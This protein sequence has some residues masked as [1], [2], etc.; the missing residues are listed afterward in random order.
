MTS[1]WFGTALPRA[2]GQRPLEERTAMIHPPRRSRTV[3][4]LSPV[5]MTLLTAFA[6]THT[7]VTAAQGARGTIQGRVVDARRAYPAQPSKSSI[8]RPASP[9]RRRRRAGQLPRGVPQSGELQGDRDPRG[10]S[11]PSA[12]RSRLDSPTCSRW[13]S[14]WRSV[15]L[16]DEMTVIGAPRRG[17]HHRRARS[18]R[19]RAQNPE[20]RSAR[21]A[22]VELVILAPGV[23]V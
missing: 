13:M 8:S 14:H 7:S 21:A 1:I 11:N 16:T 3:R 15:S 9:R 12:S 5:W 10:F 2:C 19:G 23:T 6:L 20:L 22:P 4:Y 18:G 17:P